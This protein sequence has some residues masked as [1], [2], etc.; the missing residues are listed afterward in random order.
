VVVDGS[1]LVEKVLDAEDQPVDVSRSAS[2][3]MAGVRIIQM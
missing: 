2:D 3:A 1:W